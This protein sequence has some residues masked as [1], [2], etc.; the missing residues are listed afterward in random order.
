[1]ALQ[2][3]ETKTVKIPLNV[4][5]FAYYDEKAKVWRA[6][7][8]TYD[9]LVGGSSTQIELTGKIRLPQDETEKP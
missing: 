4:R 2:Q 5:S 1:M 8:A 7:M 3:G 9:V 6:L